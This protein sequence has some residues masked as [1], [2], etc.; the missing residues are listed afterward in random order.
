MTRWTTADI[1]DI[2]QDLKRDTRCLMETKAQLLTVNA[3]GA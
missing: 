1:D 3:K 2:C